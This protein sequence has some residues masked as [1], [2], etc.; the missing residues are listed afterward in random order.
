MNRTRFNVQR[1]LEEVIITSGKRMG[2]QHAMFLTNEWM[3]E[4]G[5][6]C[7]RIGMEVQEY[8]QCV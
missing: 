2:R 1:R 7:H 6:N 4:V 5:C 8:L 3:Q